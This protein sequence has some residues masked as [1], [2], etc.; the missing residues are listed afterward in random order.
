M[1]KKAAKRKTK[2]ASAGR[3]AAPKAEK[4]YPV[5]LQSLLAFAEMLKK[6]GH[7]DRYLKEEKE[8]RVALRMDAKSIAFV[9]KYLDDH[10]LHADAA[11]AL[12]IKPAAAGG[13][14]GIRQVNPCPCIRR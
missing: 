9:K 10:E 5:Q 12:P 2:P 1:A 3:K 4:G 11:E 13:A 6:A 7:L 8:A 14:M